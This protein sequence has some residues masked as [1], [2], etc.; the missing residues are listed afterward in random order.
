MENEQILVALLVVVIGYIG[1][2]IQYWYAKRLESQKHQRNLRTNT[3]ADF[4]KGV[5]GVAITQK[6]KSIKE[7][8][9]MVLLAGARARIAIYGSKE[10]IES[11]ASFWRGGAILDTQERLDSFISICQ[12]IRKEALPKDQNVSDKEMSLLLFG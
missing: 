4:I 8:E 2:C 9:F 1:Y 5:A 3:Y 11:I 10:V 12:T 6:N 7:Q